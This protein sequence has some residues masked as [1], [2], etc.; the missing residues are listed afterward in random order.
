[1]AQCHACGEEIGYGSFVF[2]VMK[3]FGR[4][5]MRRTMPVFD[6]PKCGV[7]CQERAST[8][9]GFIL[10]FAVAAFLS[11]YVLLRAHVEIGEGT[12]MACGLGLG[13]AAHYGWWRRVSQLKEPHRF[14][15]E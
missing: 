11:V 9:Y 1:M 4:N 14:F 8:T 2:G 3:R 12:F 10:V 7:E 15:W 13:L 5:L 6:C